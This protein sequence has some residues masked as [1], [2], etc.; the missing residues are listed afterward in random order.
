MND[1]ELPPRLVNLSVPLPQRDV[2]MYSYQMTRQ[3]TE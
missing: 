1:R 3:K 2:H